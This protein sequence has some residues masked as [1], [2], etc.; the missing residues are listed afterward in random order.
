[1]ISLLPKGHALGVVCFGGDRRG[2]LQGPIFGPV[3]FDTFAVSSMDEEA[4]HPGLAAGDGPQ[5]IGRHA[6]RRSSGDAPSHGGRHI[7]NDLSCIEIFV[8]VLLRLLFESRPIFRRRRYDAKLTKAD[9]RTM[10]LR[11]RSPKS[12]NLPE[13]P[14]GSAS[15]SLR[16]ACRSAPRARRDRTHS[17]GLRRRDL[18]SPA[19]YRHHPCLSGALSRRRPLTGAKQYGAIDRRVTERRD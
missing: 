7:G 11:H 13:Q 1:M 10:E 3:L 5:A 17:P 19:C 18:R 16:S 2:Y 15:S 6:H 4:G 8:A 12:C 9:R 14:S